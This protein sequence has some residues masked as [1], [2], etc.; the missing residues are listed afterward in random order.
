MPHI[1]LFIYIYTVCHERFRPSDR[2]VS[3]LTLAA[4]RINVPSSRL[5]EYLAWARVHG[6]D[7]ENALLGMQPDPAIVRLIPDWEHRAKLGTAAAP[8]TPIQVGDLA[9][10]RRVKQG[11]WVYV[12]IASLTEATSY[13]RLLSMRLAPGQVQIYIYIYL[14]CLFCCDI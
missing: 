5:A 7:P 6:M 12:R 13:E 1:W 8:T 4:A 11:D 14:C 3:I 10:M 2:C 9:L